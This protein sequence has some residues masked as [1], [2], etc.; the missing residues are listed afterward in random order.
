MSFIEEVEIT[1]EN[2]DARERLSGGVTWVRKQL[3][4]KGWSTKWVAGLVHDYCPQCT[5]ITQM[6]R[7]RK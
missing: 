1:C 4:E 5:Q 6:Y 3:K 2:C 7:R